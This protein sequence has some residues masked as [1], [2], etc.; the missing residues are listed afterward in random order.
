MPL[1]HPDKT[2]CLVCHKRLSDTEIELGVGMGDDNCTC[3]KDVIRET[4][5]QKYGGLTQET[6]D[7][8]A[9]KA[10]R[11]RLLVVKEHK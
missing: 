3:W 11:E 2:K 9:L 8:R 1:K 7:S 10:V 4:N 5:E 6:R